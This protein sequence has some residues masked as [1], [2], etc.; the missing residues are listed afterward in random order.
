[1][2]E[3]DKELERRN[4]AL[5]LINQQ[6]NDLQVELDNARQISESKNEVFARFL[7]LTGD[8]DDS[9]FPVDVQKLL[10]ECTG[11]K[12]AEYIRVESEINDDEINR[13]IIES[14]KKSGLS[15][16]VDEIKAIEKISGY[17]EK[18]ETKVITQEING[19]AV[20]ISPVLY[21]KSGADSDPILRGVL[22]GI[23]EDKGEIS[24]IQKD[25][26][27]IVVVF[28]SIVEELFV[29]KKRQ[30][31]LKKVEY[32]FKAAEEIQ[33]NLLPKFYPDSDKFDIYGFNKS[34]GAVGGDFF[35]VFI[36]EPGK[37][38]C[39]M[40]DVSGKGLPAA[41]MATQMWTRFRDAVNEN[42][43]DLDNSY[44]DYTKL[45]TGEKVLSSQQFKTLVLD[46]NRKANPDEIFKRL[47]EYASET[48]D[49]YS[50]V[51]MLYLVFDEAD[52]SVLMTN[53]GHTPLLVFRHETG[54]A[55]YIELPAPPI[56]ITS[57]FDFPLK[58]I[59]VDSGDV[60]VMYTDA[61]PEAKGNAQNHGELFGEERFI[62]LLESIAEK[63]VQG[64]TKSILDHVH[65]YTDGNIS[66][67]ITIITIKV[68]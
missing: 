57:G 30:E 45:S 61:I 20:F 37:I 17:C 41:L 11:I 43:S 35:N 51:T 21:Q 4:Q 40:G 29:S 6:L 67:D 64:I 2:K 55:E 65:E 18:K 66:D 48:L 12:I 22:L 16:S 10:I 62:D 56:G 31:Q 19:N 60:L 54:K 28:S 59:H 3:N 52:N 53:G 46:A 25:L 26:F 39:C 27:Q 1:M 14:L 44:A 15:I 23:S 34:Y 42:V 13:K 8:L 38:G 7:R 24:E 49:D 32:E 33:R 5:R 47:N 9:T 58:S 68:K 36:P 63:D 50:F